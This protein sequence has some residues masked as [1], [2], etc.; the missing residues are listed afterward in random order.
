MLLRHLD[1]QVLELGAKLAL[2]VAFQSLVARQRGRGGLDREPDGSLPAASLAPL[3]CLSSAGGLLRLGS[4]HLFSIDALLGAPPG[5]L[6][7]VLLRCLLF[8]LLRDSIVTHNVN[9]FLF[10]A[11]QELV[12]VILVILIF[13]RGLRSQAVITEAALF[14]L[15]FLLFGNGLGRPLSLLASPGLFPLFSF[16][17][18][19]F[20]AALRGRLVVLIDALQILLSPALALLRRL[21]K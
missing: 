3:F 2:D 21:Y 7:V 10:L 20:R 16:R 14:L 4:R 15:G 5:L 6:C 17:L 18:K 13:Y 19:L 8:L 11:E 9:L 12:A 1:H